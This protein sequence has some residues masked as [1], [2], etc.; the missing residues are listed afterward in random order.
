MA[1]T[2]NIC[3]AFGGNRIQHRYIDLI[4]QNVNEESRSAEEIVSDI[5]DKLKKLGGE[6]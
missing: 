5:S 2:N 4:T 6:E 1:I 3:G